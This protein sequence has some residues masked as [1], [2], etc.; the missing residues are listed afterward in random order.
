MYDVYQL[1]SPALYLLHPYSGVSL[2]TQFQVRGEQGRGQGCNMVRG[3]WV[4]FR[5][6]DSLFS[7]VGINE[8]KSAEG[9]G[10]LKDARCHPFSRFLLWKSAL[11]Q[12]SVPCSFISSNLR[13]NMTYFLMYVLWPKSFFAYFRPICGKLLSMYSWSP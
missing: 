5:H 12:N 9:G 13:I 10:I 1:P 3:S 7:K 11:K 4:T 8:K 6:I 2:K